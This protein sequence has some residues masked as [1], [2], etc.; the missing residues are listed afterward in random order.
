MKTVF[1]GLSGGVDS[2]VSAYLLKKQGYQVV[3]AFLRVWEPDFLPCTAG[4]DRLDAMRVAAHLEIPFIT[5]NLEKEYKDTVVD[6]FINEYRAGRTP[7]P[8]VMCNRHIK[9]GA[10]WECAQRDGADLIATGHYAQNFESDAAFHLVRGLDDS[11]DQS[12]FLWTLTQDDLRH[13][14]FP[15][16]GIKKSEVRKIAIKA[17]LPNSK[18]RDS[19]GL[20]FLGQVDMKEFLQHYIP[21]QKGVIK[22]KTGEVIGEHDGVWF[23]TLDQR[24]AAHGGEKMYVVEKNVEENVLVADV[25]ASEIGGDSSITLS[26]MSWVG[27]P[28]NEG[29]EYEA[30]IRYHG[31]RVPV[32]LGEEQSVLFEEPTRVAQGQSIVIYD[33]V[34]EECMGGGI[35]E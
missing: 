23:Y 30:Q 31:E 6:Y 1:V 24:I 22:N 11:K 19:Q 18:K 32:T 35:V 4:Q 21:M 2:A 20:C 7:N 25:H 9:F 12:Y 17:K 14:L 33:S 16:G 15:V 34:T 29:G 8:D 27:K 5:Y 10:F 26:N 3:G 28:P 13:T